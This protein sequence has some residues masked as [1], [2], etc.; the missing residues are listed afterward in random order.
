MFIEIDARDQSLQSSMDQHIAEVHRDENIIATGEDCG[1][2][3]EF[4]N[5][6]EDLI[7]WLGEMREEVTRASQ[8][9][10]AVESQ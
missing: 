5:Q 8:W 7:E 1:H 2:I 4:C 3:I 9:A 10:S 6:I